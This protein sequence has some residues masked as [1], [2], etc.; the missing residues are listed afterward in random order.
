MYPGHDRMSRHSYTWDT[1]EGGLIV[2]ICSYNVLCDLLLGILF[3]VRHLRT[4]K[5][6]LNGGL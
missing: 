4:S 3:A 2:V 5:R 1:G 6:D